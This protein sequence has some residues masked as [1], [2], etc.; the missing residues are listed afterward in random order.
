MVVVFETTPVEINDTVNGLEEEGG[1]PRRIAATSPAIWDRALA[2]R[3]DVLLT[4]SGDEE[5]VDSFIMKTQ[6][7]NSPMFVNQAYN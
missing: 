2:E 3:V 6:I 4:T 5:G 7:N 1:G